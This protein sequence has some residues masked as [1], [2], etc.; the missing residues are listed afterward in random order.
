MKRIA[1][2]STVR[3]FGAHAATSAGIGTFLVAAAFIAMRG[4]IFTRGANAEF[5]RPAVAFDALVDG[6]IDV[7]TEASSIQ[8]AADFATDGTTIRVAPGTYVGAVVADGKSLTI[9]GAGADVTVVRG[10]GRSAV[11]SF[12]GTESQRVVVSGIAV[13]GGRGDNGTGLAFDGVTYD[14]RDCHIAGNQGSGVTIHGGTGAFSGCKFDDNR[15]E[16]SGG[17]VSN[18]GGSP[19]FVACS[20]RHNISATFGGALY[21]KGGNVSLLACTVE[22]NST[23]SG[24]WG[25][26]VFGENTTFE[27]HGTDF[28]R[29]RSIESGGAVYLL[30]GIAD[31]SRCTFTGNF[32]DEARSLYSRGAGVR[33]ASSRLCGAEAFALG[34]DFAFG[35]GNVFDTSCFGDCNQN[36]V[37]DEEEIAMGW[38][39]DRDGNGVPDSC[40]PDCNSNG[41]PDGY[42]V[43]AGFA[44]DMN[45]NGLIDICEIRAGLALDV[46][47]DWIPDDAQMTVKAPVKAPVAAAPAGMKSSAAPVN[48]PFD[49][50]GPGMSGGLG[51]MN[52]PMSGFPGGH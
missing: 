28:A 19:S 10:F 27:L 23:R 2:T 30:G 1:S 26:A 42:E 50:W 41:L 51:G 29:N 44:Q 39:S 3:H 36:G 35:D 21:S 49:A 12:S 13:V 17:A 33:I 38:I 14:V 46:D 25:G 11:F 16:N 22:D 45:A 52:G 20:F 4:G 43:S 34:G 47:N 15:S 32:S 24:A 9:I 31:V 6:V 48:D 8:A 5:I 37:S 7:P 40:D 18:D